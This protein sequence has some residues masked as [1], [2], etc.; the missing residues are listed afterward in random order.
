MRTFGIWIV[1][2]VLTVGCSQSGTVTLSGED[3]HGT[4]LWTEEAGAGDQRTREDA[5]AAVPDVPPPEEVLDFSKPDEGGAQCNPGEGCFLDPCQQNTDCQSGFCVEHLGESVCSMTCKEECPSGWACK[6]FSEAGRDLVYVCVSLHANLCKPCATGADCTSSGGGADVCVTYPGEGSFCGGACETSADCPF[7]FMCKEATTV[8]GTESK[9]CISDA[10]TC[11]CTARSVALGLATPCEKAAE[12]GICQGQ[13]VCTGE[14]L[15]PCDAQEPAKEVC[16]AADDDCDG[17]VDEADF[18]RGK[19]V[20][21]CDDGNDCT[22]DL[23][24]GDGG[25]EHAAQTGTEC[26]DGNPCTVADLCQQGVCAGTPVECDD[27][28]P[29]TDDA[30]N[31]AGGCAFAANSAKCDDS[32]PCTVADACEQKECKGFAV[33]CDCQ[34]DGNCAVLEDGNLCNGT[35]FCDTGKLPYQCAVKKGTE[36]VCPEPSGVDAPCRTAVCDPATGKCGFANAADKT[37]CDDAD[38]CTVND[39]CMGGTCMPGITANCNDGNVCTEDVCEPKNGCLHLPNVEECTDGNFCTVKDTCSAGK[40]LGGNPLVCDDG[41][42]CTDDSCDPKTGCQAVPNQ[43]ACDDGSQCTAGDHCVGGQ[44]VS[45]TAVDCNDNNLCTKDACVPFSGCVYTAV[46]G[47][48]SDGNPC[49]LNDICAKGVCTPGPLVSCDDGNPCTDD[50]CGDKGLCAHKLNQAAC[51]DSNQCTA[52]DQCKGGTCAWASLVDCDDSNP[53]TTDSCDPLQGCVHKT[54]AAPCNDGNL[55][56]IGDTCSQGKCS[57]P[58][59]M[60]C[61]D[62]NPCTDD[63][64]DPMAGCQHA[65]NQAQCNDGNP[66]TVGDQCAAG[67]CKGSQAVDCDDDNVCTTDSCDPLQGCIHKT[68]TAPCNDGNVCTMQDACDSGACKGGALVA[69]GDDNPCTDDFCDP[70]LGCQHKPNTAPCEDGNKCTVDDVCGAAACKPGKAA[71]CMDGNVCTDDGCN[72]VTG[73][74]YTPNSSGCDDGNLCT[75]SDKCID[76]QCKAGDAV[77]CDDKNLCTDDS[78]SPANGCIFLPNAVP[79]NDGNVCTVGD[80]CSNGGCTSGPALNCDDGNACTTDSCQ[81]A[82]GCIHTPLP[83]GADCGGGKVCANGVCTTCPNPHGSK[84]F[85]FTGGQQTWAVPLCVTSVT[86]EAWGAQGGGSDCCGGGI[87]DDG[88]LGGYAKGTL[89]VVPGETLYVYVGGKGQVAG[90]GGWNGGGSGAQYGGG[91]G[92]ASDVRKGG[93]SLNDRKLVG[94]AGGAGNCGCPDHGSGGYGGG[95]TGG[96]GAGGWTPGGGGTQTEGGAAGSNCSPGT[97]GNGGSNAAYHMAG[98]GGGWY[99]GG[100]AYAAGGGGGSSYHGGCTNG[101][102]SSN[103]RSGSGQVT[104]TW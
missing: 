44:C 60:K 98:G 14:G 68:N 45:D 95:L 79:C 52:G 94:G 32:N 87:Q 96:T 90:A 17:D 89:A 102:T 29:C 10:G 70:A 12:F 76:G 46:E 15:T 54:N 61:D 49:T 20:P 38:A 41:N 101:S 100:C 3:V 77:V 62:S 26:K 8:T 59:Q 56:T 31:E 72:P 55:C 91:G 64:C 58:V 74:V 28:N 97:F 57:S 7:G 84:T 43:A 81:P 83:E 36:V 16:N 69:C 86:L 40:C 75:K 71:V 6:Q 103:T 9:Q 92:G 4:D 1:C 67:L 27:N 42:V 24:L 21:L 85:S 5:D 50:S 63:F 80:T 19:Y 25:C 18:V 35:L 13:R 39:S 73:C 34:Q 51:D 30:C 2:G 47:P 66:C 37:P 33:A 78:C 23:C 93:T 53:C 104:I 99:G 88:G 48:C 82:N 65:P 11:P 22:E